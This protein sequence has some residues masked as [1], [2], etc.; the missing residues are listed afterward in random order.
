MAITETR[1]FSAI[2]DTVVTRSGRVDRVLDIVSYA[3]L[4]M[5]ELESLTHFS[6]TIEEHLVVPTNDP[7][8]WDRPANYRVMVAVKYPD[9]IDSQGK[10]VYPKAITV[11]KATDTYDCAYYPSGNSYVF[12]GHQ[13]TRIAL[14]FYAFLPILPF[15]PVVSDRPARFVQDSTTGEEKWVYSG[16]N[17]L[18][19]TAQ[20]AAQ[21]KVQNWLIDRWFDLILEGTLAKLYKLVGDERQLSTYALYKQLQNTL[22]ASEPH[23]KIA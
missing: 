2:V 7:Y 17:G 1:T 6:R 14:A 16:D 10:A 18:N 15:F 12:F 21:T 13:N 9:L 19:A 4:T 11:G 5:R 22:L 23:D 3:R 20:T 8:V